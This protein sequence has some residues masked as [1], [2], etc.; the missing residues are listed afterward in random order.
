MR[1]PDGLVGW[2]DLMT[3]DVEAARAFYSDLFGWTS[4]DMP[5]PMGPNYTQFYKDGKVVAG[6]GPLPPDMSAAGVPSQWNSY[7]I[8][9]DLDSKL[10]KV[11]PAGGQVVMPAM[12]VMTQGRMAMV[13]DPSGAVIGLW[14]P[15]DHQGA[16]LFSVPGAQTW[17]ELQSRDVEAA[18]PFYEAVFGWR[19]VD[20]GQPGYWM[21]NLDS[22]PGDDKSNAGAMGMPEGVPPEVPSFWG[23]YFAV[24]DCDAALARATEL[25]ATV[26]FPVMEMGPMRFAGITDPTGAFVM[27]GAF[28]S[29]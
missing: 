7:V 23:V 26:T 5:T 13:A 11:G 2:V 16:E 24:A 1:H 3:S 25:G 17:N 8:V 22:K 15:Q 9:E 6:M 28:P 29:A 21:A 19:W 4:Q 12:D 20:S 18:M 14:Q 27:F 10:A